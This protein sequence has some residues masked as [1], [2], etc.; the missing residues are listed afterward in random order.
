VS[1]GGL[2]VQVTAFE[3][4]SAAD[5]DVRVISHAFHVN[6]PCSTQHNIETASVYIPLAHFNRMDV[7]AP[8]LKSVTRGIY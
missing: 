7:V 6:I 2:A 1:L 8:N 5:T 4:A 3:F